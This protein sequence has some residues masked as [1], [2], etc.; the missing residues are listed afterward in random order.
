M[1]HLHNQMDI[2]VCVCTFRRPGV[3]E[4]LASLS[5]MSVPPKVNV[6]VLVVDNDTSPS[7]QENVEAFAKTASLQIRYVHCPSGN[8]SIARNGALEHS[9]TRYLAFVDDDETVAQDWL[10]QMVKTARSSGA[11][12]VLG[13]VN[14]IY[15]DFAPSWMKSKQIHSTRPVWVNGAIKTGYTCNVLI[16]REKPAVSELNFDLALGQSGGEDTKYFSQVT[17]AG[18]VIVYSKDAYVYEPVPD[19][20]TSFTWLMHRKF[21]AGQT[22]GHLTGAGKSGLARV[23]MMMTATAKLGYC[24]GTALLNLGSET[25]RN[26]AFLRGTLHAGTVMGLIGM[27]E[28]QQYGLKMS[29]VPQR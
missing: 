5:R 21:R 17:T 18:G 20:R 7:A 27:R 13:P 9:D 15:G 29:E 19:S 3:T 14:A 16:D 8:I 23:K 1:T 2:E 25:K 10:L 12:V 4:T 11:D 28:L 24:T 22:H 6:S 26:S